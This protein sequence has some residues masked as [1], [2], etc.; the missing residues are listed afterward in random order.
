M[1]VFECLSTSACQWHASCVTQHL[2]VTRATRLTQ[3]GCVLEKY[4][5]RQAFPARPKLTVEFAR[6]KDYISSRTKVGQ[7]VYQIAT[8]SLRNFRVHALGPKQSP[9]GGHR[10]P[11]SQAWPKRVSAGG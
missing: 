1:N 6:E 8:Q 2:M 3:S 7:G 9:G 5:C 11:D 10:G 4:R